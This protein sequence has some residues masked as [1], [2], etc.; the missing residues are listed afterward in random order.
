ME[1]NLARSLALAGKRSEAS[2]LAERLAASGLAPYRL[3]TIHAALGETEQAIAMIERAWDVRD[4]WLVVLKVDPMLDSI[5]SDRRIRAI[6]KEV[7]G[8]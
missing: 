1:S 7:L 5:R 4:P 8:G 6:E 2:A 3:A